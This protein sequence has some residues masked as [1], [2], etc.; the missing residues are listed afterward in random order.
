MLGVVV[1]ASVLY[2]T[3][4]KTVTLSVD[5]KTSEV[6][7][8]SKTVDDLLDKQGI[9]VGDKDIVAPAPT[10]ELGD[11]DTVVVRYARP[12][13]L[14]VDGDKRTYWTTEL[15]VERALSALGVRAEGASLSASRSAGSTGPDWPCGC[16]PRSRSR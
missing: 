3:L 14:T 2:S 9:A 10:A 8:F 11:G 4:D 6:H 5:G 13:T 12:L 1:G 16:P 15:S 7:A